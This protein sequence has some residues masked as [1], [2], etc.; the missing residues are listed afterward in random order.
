MPRCGRRAGGE[1][2]RVGGR[3][4]RAAGRAMRGGRS[5]PPSSARSAIGRKSGRA[6]CG[7]RRDQAGSSRA[8]RPGGWQPAAGLGR[9]HGA[10]RA[11]AG[12]GPGRGESV[13]PGGR[14]GA[15]CGLAEVAAGRA[16]DIR[17]VPSDR[18]QP[19]SGLRSG[20]PRRSPGPPGRGP[21]EPAARPEPT[22]TVANLARGSASPADR[23]LRAAPRRDV[24]SSCVPVPRTL[25]R[26]NIVGLSHEFGRRAAAHLRPW[27]RTAG[28]WLVGS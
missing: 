1:G 22:R 6:R 14:R 21:D 26:T 2:P 18:P 27:P 9:S 19:G 5:E 15:S 11:A 3:P 12:G 17:S 4:K 24:K 20:R 23:R 10:G 25:V 13:G 8:D 28:P 7:G 16:A